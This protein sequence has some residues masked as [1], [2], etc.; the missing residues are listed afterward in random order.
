MET[1]TL[2]KL[3]KS[4]TV[5]SLPKSWVDVMGLKRGDKV[6]I[7]RLGDGTLKIIPKGITPSEGK[8]IKIDI[9]KVSDKKLLERILMAYYLESADKISLFS[10]EN[11][12]E[13]VRK[14]ANSFISQIGEG[15]I[16]EKENEL[17]L[18]IDS[19]TEKFSMGQLISEMFANLLSMFSG[20]RKLIETKDQGNKENI[21]RFEEKVDLLYH[22]ALRKLIKAQVNRGIV[23]SMGLE[24]PLWILGN[25]V[26]IKSIEQT[27][28]ALTGLIDVTISLLEGGIGRETEEA[29]LDYIEEIEDLIPEAINC[30]REHDAYLAHSLFSRIKTI[31]TKIYELQGKEK[32][33]EAY[34]EFLTRLEVSLDSLFGTLEVV[35]NRSAL[36]EPQIE[37]VEVLELGSGD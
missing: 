15:E 9:S 22:F 1:R 10:S 2:V 28:D 14:V 3:G 17:S 29:L 13:E 4:S 11:D 16:E 37:G 8:K 20:L 5:V 6:K 24:T 25:R 33:N 18:V 36:G 31:Q 34:C 19:T 26:V 12:L 23:K 32:K 30:F 27:A 35:L 21:L 7:Q